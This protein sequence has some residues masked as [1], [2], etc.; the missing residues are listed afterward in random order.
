MFVVFA[1]NFSFSF[2][3]ATDT[4]PKSIRSL[5]WSTYLIETDGKADIKSKLSKIKS[6]DS[7]SCNVEPYDQYNTAQ[8]IIYV[9]EF[10]II[11]FS[12]FEI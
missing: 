2:K 11:F 3:E 9:T 1:I 8:G 6:I 12:K 5:N 10:D 7:V 4:A